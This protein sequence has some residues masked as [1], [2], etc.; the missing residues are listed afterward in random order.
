[1]TSESQRIAIAEVC[2]WKKVDG[3]PAKH[4]RDR[5]IDPKYAGRYAKDY[6]VLERH[7]PDYLNDLNIMHEAEKVLTL[8]QCDLFDEK[9]KEIL[10]SERHATVHDLYTWHATA[11]QRAQAFLI[12]LGLWTK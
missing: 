6:A 11:A 12:T 7:L 1:M 5:W 9:L 10:L 2:G 3:N 4:T 8:E